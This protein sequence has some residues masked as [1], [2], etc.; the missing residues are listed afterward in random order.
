M[1]IYIIYSTKYKIIYINKKL[2]HSLLTHIYL[3]AVTHK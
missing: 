1:I 2:A 3:C